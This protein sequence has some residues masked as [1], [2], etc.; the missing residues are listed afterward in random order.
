[1]ADVNFVY[2][3][4]VKYDIADLIARQSAAA[5]EAQKG[6]PYGIAPLDS[7]GNLA[8]TAGG[9]GSSSA[10][11]A[12]Y[13]LLGDMNAESGDI[14]DTT[15]FVSAYETASA[16][17]GAVMKRTA[18]KIYNYILSKLPIGVANGIASLDASG[19]VPYAQLPVDAMTFE[20]EAT[21]ATPTPASPVKGM[22][23]IVTEAGT[24]F[25]V[26][27]CEVDDRLIYDGNDF[28]LLSS[29]AVKSVNG[30]TGDVVLTA[31][32]IGAVSASWNAASHTLTLVV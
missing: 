25:G 13:N 11:G 1:M 5:I 7:N 4:G 18:L 19:R 14:S 12:Q 22:F 28:V 32:D 6:E 16:S 29:G 23:W 9:T 24:V 2:V 10:K 15:E 17:I 27:D 20:G 8:V 3:K 21:P 26:P 31:S 30:K